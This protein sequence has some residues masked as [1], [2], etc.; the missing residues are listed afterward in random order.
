MVNVNQKKKIIFVTGG[1]CSS[2]GKG[3]V[4]AS[5]GKLL[6]ALGFSIRIIKIDPYLNE[7]AGTMNPN[8]HG[9]VWVTKSGKETDLDGGTYFRFLNNEDHHILYTSGNILKHM[10][11]KERQG[12]YQGE[13]VR[14]NPHFVNEIKSLIIDHSESDISLVEIGGT[15][16]ED[17]LIPYLQTIINMQHDENIEIMHINVALAITLQH[18][19]ETKVKPIENLYRLLPYGIKIDLQIIRVGQPL[20]EKAIQKIQNYSFVKNII[21]LERAESVYEIPLLLQQQKVHEM[22]IN[23]FN[24]IPIKNNITLEHFEKIIKVQKD[25]KATVLKGLII[26]KYG[27]NMEVYKSIDEAILHAATHLEVKA[28]VDIFDIN[29]P[30]D[31]IKNYDFVVFSGGFGV[32][33]SDKLMEHLRFVRQNNIPTL[34]ICFGLQLSLI[35]IARNLLQIPNA[36]STE[37]NEEGTPIICLVDEKHNPKI[38]NFGGTLRVGVFNVYLNPT[39][40]LYK[41]YKQLERIDG[42]NVIKEKFRHRYWINKNF[43]K[44]FET[45]GIHFSMTNT[46]SKEDLF[47]F[48]LDS[49]IHTFFV[50]TQFHPELSSNIY[51]PHPIFICLI[52]S[53]LQS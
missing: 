42:N 1:S 21:G 27:N 7:D 47:G 5:I 24:L 14:I 26:S 52:R 53:A 39:S 8:E 22:I 36:T 46:G 48:E 23:H 30:S 12:F 15:I 38:H 51:V 41:E 2:V 40:N 16:G 9:E 49:N 25:N 20:T 32:N 43:R 45:H 3:V 4:I 44:Q 19:N 18:T 37:F 50:G 10:F 35:E 29:S 34:A 13:N 33:S 28:T 31:D 6:E 17:E 11:E